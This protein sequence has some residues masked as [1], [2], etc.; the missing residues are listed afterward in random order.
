MLAGE[1][2]IVISP[3]LDDGV[4]S[5]GMLLAASA[6]PSVV[7][8]FAG[9]PDGSLVAPDWDRRAGF[10]TA[11]EAMQARRQEDQCGLAQLDARPVWLNF[12]DSQ[13]EVPAAAGEIATQLA[14]VL[15]EQPAAAVAAPLGLFHSDHVLVHQAA[16]AL[17]RES[18]KQRDWLFYE[19]ALYR[20]VPGLVQQRLAAWRDQQIVATPIDFDLPRFSARKA[21][22]ANA[23]ASQ[24]ALFTPE[25]LEDLR[26]PERYWQLQCDA[27]C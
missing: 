20:R 7:T 3:H 5:C 4:F 1:T 26:A 9:V 8:V 2:V 18:Q 12:M 16:L 10:A 6:M 23:Y 25:R 22:A 27:T 11:A 19:D 15:H 17:W 21:A 13:Y 14:S 24:L